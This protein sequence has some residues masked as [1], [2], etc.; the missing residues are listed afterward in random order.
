MKETDT[1]TQIPIMSLCKYTLL[2]N[3]TLS[4]AGESKLHLIWLLQFI[5]LFI[6]N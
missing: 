5:Q 6:V 2:F 4:P 1:T 3:K